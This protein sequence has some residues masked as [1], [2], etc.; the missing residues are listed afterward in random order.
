MGA[1]CFEGLPYVVSRTRC[2]ALLPIG[3]SPDW[4]GEVARRQ[5]ASVTVL[6][7]GAMAVGETRITG[8]WKA[9]DVLNKQQKSD[10]RRLV[11]EVAPLNPRRIGP[12]MVWALGALPNARP[13]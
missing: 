12:F 2:A 1:H 7:L 13:D 4:R 10:G 3:Q 11:A 8:F 9:I 6:I 5:I